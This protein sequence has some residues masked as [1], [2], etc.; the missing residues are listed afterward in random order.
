M[1]AADFRN[2]LLEEAVPGK[3]YVRGHD[4]DGRAVVYMRPGRENTHN[5]LNNMRHLVW[6]MEKAIAVTEKRG[7]QKI[8]FVI[9]Y[10]GFSLMNAPPLSTNRYTLDIM[11]RHYP[12]RCHRFYLTNPPFVFRAVWAAIKPL[13]DPHTKEKI[14][15]S[16]GS[17]GIA[18]LVE[19]LGGDATKLEAC[20][21]GTDTDNLKPFDA[22]EYLN[23][24]FD[25]TFDHERWTN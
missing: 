16:S 14:V 21:G 20:A 5:Q 1:T 17:E 18:S 9:D 15:F 3:I 13:V 25:Q 2:I 23:L 24:P 6:N 8:V 10:T 7:L 19:D 12:E 11:Q 4:Q 22:E